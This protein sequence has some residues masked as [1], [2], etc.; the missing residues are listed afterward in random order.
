LPAS[1]IA[2][3]GIVVVPLDVRLGDDGPDVMRSLSPE[4]FW[5][6]CAKTTELPETSAPSPGA[7]QE[8]F[9][10]AKSDGC[11]G[12][13]CVTISSA[14]SGTYQAACAGAKE[15]EGEIDVRVVDSR[16]ASMA[17][18]LMVVDAGRRAAAGEEA[19]PIAAVV[20]DSIPKMRL[21]GMIETL[22]NLRRGG[23]I[24]GAQAFVGSLLSFKPIIEVREGVVEK[25]SRQRTRTRSLQYL[26]DKVKNA[27]EI[28]QLAILHAM[29]PDIDEFAAMIAEVY[30]PEKTI[31]GIIGPVIGTHCGPGAAGVAFQ[32]A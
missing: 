28:S 29:A 22:E 15:L 30:P 16:F 14:M 27:S 23:R 1:E 7:F 6:R 24:G 19:A 11:D 18:G 31:I 21:Y 25:E 12:V 26:V 20:T 2:R 8:V 4:E 17:Q 10:A 3:H 13:V 5:E 32:L 9:A